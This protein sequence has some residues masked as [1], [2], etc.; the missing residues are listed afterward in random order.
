MLRLDTLVM[1]WTDQGYSTHLSGYSK[2]LET[3]STTSND[4][5][6]VAEP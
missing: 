2:V 6:E 5:A 4:L 1:D 3:G